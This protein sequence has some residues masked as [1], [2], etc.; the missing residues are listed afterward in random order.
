VL[1]R[2]D[3]VLRVRHQAKDVARRVAESGNVEK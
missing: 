2:M 3:V 1:V